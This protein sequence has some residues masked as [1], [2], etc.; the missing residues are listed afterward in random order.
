MKFFFWERF[1]FIFYKYFVVEK[2]SKEISC[3]KVLF[4][5]L[6]LV[7]LEK[8]VRWFRLKNFVLFLK[9]YIYK[10]LY[11][12]EIKIIIFVNWFDEKEWIKVGK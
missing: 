2:L 3:W 5:K 1:K 4:W 7:W 6:W 8:S 10:I 12:K 11:N 9:L